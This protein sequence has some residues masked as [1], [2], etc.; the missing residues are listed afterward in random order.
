MYKNLNAEL[1][2]GN[3][4]LDVL[5]ER[6]GKSVPA[7]SMNLSGK[8]KLTLTEAKI[9]QATIYEINGIYLTLDELFKEAG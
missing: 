6:L 2:R 3:I 4:G 8:T 1:A 5:A 9:I 7:V